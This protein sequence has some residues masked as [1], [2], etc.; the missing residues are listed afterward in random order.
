MT[1]MLLIRK[2]PEPAA[3]TEY[4][5]RKWNPVEKQSLQPSYADMPTEIKDEIRKY[6]LREQGCLCAYCMR[7]LDSIEDVKIEHWTPEKD[8]DEDGKLE[9]RNMLGVCYGQAGPESGYSGR[10]YETCD[11]RRGSRALNVDPRSPVSIEKISYKSGTGEITCRDEAIRKD[12]TDTLNL[13][14]GVPHFLPEN[15]KAV[16]DSVI[17]HLN[18]K[19]GKS[20]KW[21]RNE[22]MKVRKKFETPDHKGQLMEYAGIVLW[23]I[24]SRLSR[25][26]HAG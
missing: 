23:F 21:S 11:Q 17:R 22:M 2:G 10:E 9:Y 25:E 13:N 26:K 3:L 4:R 1:E 12:L 18:Q 15:R 7:R 8:L 5:I 24:D 20:G 6:L 14:C 19:A 16:L